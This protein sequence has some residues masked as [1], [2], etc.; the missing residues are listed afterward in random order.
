MGMWF[1][2][3]YL[4]A[5]RISDAINFVVRLG[6]VA[7]MHVAELVI[8]RLVMLHVEV[9]Q[10]QEHHVGR[11]AVLLEEIADI[12]AL[13]FVILLYLVLMSDASSLSRLLALVPG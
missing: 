8:H 7:Y 5:Q 4:V 3:T 13:Q 11:R 12:L 1:W 9:K 6:S 10:V 2:G